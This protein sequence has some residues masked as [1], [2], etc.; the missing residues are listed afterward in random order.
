METSRRHDRARGA[1]RHGAGV[2]LLG[3]PR[4]ARQE[5]LETIPVPIQNDEEQ[6]V[7]RVTVPFKLGADQA[8][9]NEQ[10]GRCDHPGTER[11]QR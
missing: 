9:T 3:R 6:G 10:V 7:R 8:A 2:L 5:R 4:K 11:N 1:A